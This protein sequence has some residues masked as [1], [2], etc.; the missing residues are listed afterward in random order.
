MS[1]IWIR[2]PLYTSNHININYATI[3]YGKSVDAFWSG[4]FVVFCRI[5]YLAATEIL[6]ILFII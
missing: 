1:H 5:L 2:Q 6:P 4:W 3:Q